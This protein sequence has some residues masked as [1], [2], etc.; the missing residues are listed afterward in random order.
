MKSRIDQ[1]QSVIYRK[2]LDLWAIALLVVL[3]L[4]SALTQPA[5][6][7]PTTGAATAVGS[8]NATLHATGVGAIGWFEYGTM[9]GYLYWKTPNQT[10]T[11]GTMTYRVAQSPLTGNTLWIYRAC[12]ATGC[13]AEATFVTLAV[14]PLPTLHLGSFYENITES[15]FDI[16]YMATNLIDPFVW[17][18]NVPLTVVFMLCFSPIF[19]GVWLR[20]RTV[21]VALLLGFI[22]GSFILYA[23]RG[24]NLGMPAE[25][26]SLSQAMCYVAFAGIVVY[27]LKR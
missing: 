14:T 13:G 23:D 12:D 24:L 5:S 17:N 21:M 18:P 2:N 6:A 8:N 7:I 11:G 4:I 3:A 25:I 10:V 27:I 1:T 19:I 9:S 15:G 22:T 16:Q 20:S 26:I